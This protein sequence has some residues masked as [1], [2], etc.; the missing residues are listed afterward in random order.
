MDKY[1]DHA[2]VV[3]SSSF[4]VDDGIRYLDLVRDQ[5]EVSLPLYEGPVAPLSEKPK[6]IAVDDGISWAV[7]GAF[8][9]NSALTCCSASCSNMASGCSHLDRY[10]GRCDEE[11]TDP[12]LIGAGSDTPMNTTRSTKPIPFPLPRDLQTKCHDFASGKQHYPNVI[13]LEADLFDGTCSCD[14]KNRW[15]NQRKLGKAKIITPGAVI[16]QIWTD[17]Q[18]SDISVYV[19]YTENCSCTLSPDGQSIG[20]LNVDDRHFIT[21]S[22]LLLFLSILIHGTPTFNLFAT[23]LHYVYWFTTG[24]KDFSVAEMRRIVRPGVCF[25]LCKKLPR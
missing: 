20:L 22:S 4:L 23:M 19:G 25:Y 10:K 12:E 11:G 9:S 8:G 7:L 2:K 3:S 5:E 13:Q 1:C 17:G 6:L 16:D 18:A 14:Q 21:Y 15:V 24:A